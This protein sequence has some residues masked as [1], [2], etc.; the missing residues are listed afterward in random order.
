MSSA[1]LISC[2][3]RA[4]LLAVKRKSHSAESV[5][6][7]RNYD[8]TYT[9]LRRAAKRSHY[10]RT[11]EACKND[12]KQTWNTIREVTGL[13]KRSG[14]DLPAVFTHNKQAYEGPRS[15]AEG[16]NTFFS[17]IGPK[18]AAKIPQ[19]SPSA[20]K[21]YLP[22]PTE[23]QFFFRSLSEKKILD[24]IGKM[25]PKTSSGADFVS[26][27]LLK[28]IAP[29]IIAPLQYMINLS[30]SKGVVPD[31]V[32]IAKII[33]I[34]KMAGPKDDFNSYRPISILS[35]FG[36]LIEKVVCNQLMGY[37]MENNLLYQHQYGFRSGCNTTHPLLHFTD[38]IFEAL[39]STPAKFNLSVFID[40][41]KAFDTVDFEILLAKL[42]HY[43]VRGT[44]NE[45][46]RS[47]LS[48]RTQY[49]IIN[50]VK[51]S[52]QVVKC[53]VPQG[54]VTGPLLFLIFINDICRATELF[55]LLYADDTTFQLSGEDLSI[56]Y[57]QVNQELEKARRWFQANKLTLNT[58]KTKYMIF[59]NPNLKQHVHYGVLSIGQD[60]ISRVGHN[61]N[62][63][64][65]KFLGH[66][67]DDKLSWTS[68]VN[69]IASKLMSA[70]FALSQAKN[71][72]PKSIKLSVYRALFES[73]LYSAPI[74]GAACPSTV[75]RLNILQK[76]AVRL[77]C[78][79]KMNAHSE[80]LLADL[81][82]LKA[83]DQIVLQQV[84]FVNN[85]RN[86]KHPKSFEGYFTSLSQS[87][88][89]RSRKDDYDLV[90]PVTK[91]GLSFFPKGRIIGAWNH[92][93]LTTKAI[94][95]PKCFVE[96]VR[97]DLISAYEADCCVLGCIVCK[98]PPQTQG[99][100]AS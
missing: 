25:K 87:G 72:L 45:W 24:I 59:K 46:F 89:R 85:F 35:S 54:S 30:L 1:L 94:S 12:L 66:H 86:E 53:G 8:K 40:L 83:D 3:T 13:S 84:T 90:R 20:F 63:T 97:A 92:L 70:N 39:S 31:Q 61:C 44:E 71:L 22:T 38:K 73:H 68:H 6:Q 80:P 58:D 65:F 56:L 18:L 52:S 91:G 55:T 50:G 5:S 16:F 29:V 100:Y 47:Y 32:K 69:Q 14:F 99:R 11:F 64:S 76:R 77:I 75:K 37:L 48:N 88:Q 41:K 9:T 74:W 10:T 7:L 95:E 21:S 60:V 23:E 67:V 26:N 78:N 42:K 81:N 57:L 79:S 4:K 62:E 82:I 98:P 15:I 28:T 36:K 43:G 2:K 27:K 34:Y 49:V 51:S 33:P 96:Q 17:T 93:D 19:T